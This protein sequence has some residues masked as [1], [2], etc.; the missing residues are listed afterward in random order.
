MVVVVARKFGNALKSNY[1]GDL[2]IGVHIVEAV[3]TLHHRRQQ[4][5]VRK[6]LGAVEVT[7]VARDGVCVG[8][9]LVHSSVLVV[10]HLL[11]LLVGEVGGEVYR[12]IRKSEEELFG[13]LVATIEPSVAKSGVHLVD[14]V[15]WSPR[16]EIG[17]EVAFLEVAPNLL[18]VGHSAYVSA[19]PRRM[20]FGVGGG[21]F[22]EFG[23]EV[24]H[25]SAA[26]V[27]ACGGVES[28][29]CEVMTANVSVKTVPIWVWLGFWRES[30]LF[31]VWREKPVTIV[32]EKGFDVEVA[33]GFERTVQ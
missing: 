31:A 4:S 1:F 20:V 12:P 24:F 11:H 14:V 21:T 30:R 16:A 23:D 2:R 32:L 7:L 29:C 5:A 19:P 6:P 26:L 27:V 33:G 28:H 13:V 9:Y 25:T 17:A 8:N 10:E 3:V 22:F 15:K 18:A